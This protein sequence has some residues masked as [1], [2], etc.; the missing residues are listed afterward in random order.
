MSL[1]LFLIN[2]FPFVDYLIYVIF[3]FIFILYSTEIKQEP[4]E[5]EGITENGQVKDEDD[6]KEAGELVSSKLYQ[7]IFYWL[8]QTD[9]M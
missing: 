5:D 3:V 9:S 4:K 1:K 2:S 8:S 6:A 7:M